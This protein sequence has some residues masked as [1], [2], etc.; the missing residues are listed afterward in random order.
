MNLAGWVAASGGNPGAAFRLLLLAAVL[1]PI[2]KTAAAARVGVAVR[3]SQRGRL[4]FFPKR[5]LHRSFERING[6]PYLSRN[7]ERVMIANTAST[8][9]IVY[10]CQGSKLELNRTNDSAHSFTF[11]STINAGNS[12]ILSASPFS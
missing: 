11:R 6:E 4:L 12:Q 8:A 2:K 7:E 10:A 9:P 5:I 3:E 1:L